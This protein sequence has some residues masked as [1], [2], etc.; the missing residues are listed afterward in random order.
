MKSLRQQCAKLA[1]LPGTLGAPRTE[2]RA[3]L[4]SLAFKGSVILFRYE[5]ETIEIVNFIEG[6]R[7]IERMFS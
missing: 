6:H 5:G 4:R 3:D 1:A 2:L 7:D